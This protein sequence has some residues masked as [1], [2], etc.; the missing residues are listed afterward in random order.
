VILREAEGVGIQV[1]GRADELRDLV[2]EDDLVDEPRVD[3]GRLE[4]LL[5]RRAEAERLLQDDDPA[6]GRG[7]RDLE[8]LLDA[9]RGP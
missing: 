4:G 9:R 8:Q 5:G 7:L 3:R 1:L 2:D 6:V